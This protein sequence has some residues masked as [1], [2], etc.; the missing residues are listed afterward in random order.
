MCPAVATATAVLSGCAT[1]PGASAQ[2]PPALVVETGPE[3][4]AGKISTALPPGCSYEE[5]VGLLLRRGVA[6][7][8]R[9]TSEADGKRVHILRNARNNM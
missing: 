5:A 3:T 9:T 2:F 1:D 4:G 7:S 8:D 6:A